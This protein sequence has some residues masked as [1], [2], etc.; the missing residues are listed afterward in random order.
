MWSDADQIIWS[1]YVVGGENSAS[2]I[3]PQVLYCNLEK[4]IC[5]VILQLICCALFAT[6]RSDATSLTQYAASVIAVCKAS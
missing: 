1:N 4:R 3:P 2:F 6:R 5:Q